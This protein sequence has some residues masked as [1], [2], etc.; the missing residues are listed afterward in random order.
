MGACE[1]FFEVRQP[2]IVSQGYFT[3]CPLKYKLIVDGTYL[4]CVTFINFGKFFNDSFA[5]ASIILSIFEIP[6]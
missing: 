1:Y 5:I 3:Q 4:S 2:Y 6:S